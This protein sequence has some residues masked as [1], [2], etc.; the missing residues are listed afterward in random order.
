MEQC[1]LL[2]PRELGRIWLA[3]KK[4]K[5][6]AGKWNGY[7]GKF[8]PEQGDKT[9][10]DTALREF[11]EES[12]AE[13][14]GCERL[15]RVAVVNFFEAGEHLFECHVYFFHAEYGK[16]WVGRLKET[17]EMGKPQYF[18]LWGIPFESMMPADSLF[19]KPLMSGK[20][21]LIFTIFYSEG[22]ERVEGHAVLESVPAICVE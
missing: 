1:T 13:L 6:G 10:V 4:K 17:E 18:D 11:V 20:K 7:G 12:G 14:T 21:N 3:P 2:F 16:S 8:S 9:M 19:L 5:V 15:E 22:K